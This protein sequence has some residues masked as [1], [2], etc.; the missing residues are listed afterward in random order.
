MRL[1]YLDTLVLRG[2]DTLR[3]WYYES[4]WYY[5]C[6][7]FACVFVCLLIVSLLLRH[8]VLKLL[9]GCPC[10]SF[11][12]CI[13]ILSCFSFFPCFLS[14]F[15]RSLFDPYTFLLLRT[16]GTRVES[17]DIQVTNGA[18]FKPRLRQKPKT[19]KAPQKGCGR[20]GA[21]RGDIRKIKET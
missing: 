14:S 13:C 19:S 1:W 21:W 2:H 7:C 16:P 8:F 10:L 9:F 20:N 11:E 17:A 18:T 4:K 12:N 15:L 3:I 5:V 6:Y